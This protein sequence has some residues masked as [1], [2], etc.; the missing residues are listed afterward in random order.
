MNHLPA[1]LCLALAFPALAMSPDEAK[2]HSSN[3][4]ISAAKRHDPAAIRELGRRREQS[5]LRLLREIAI[6]PDVVV[7]DDQV[8]KQKTWASKSAARDKWM[9]DT[10]A[11]QSHLFAK[12]A[13]ARMGDDKYF[14]EFIV[15]ISS[16]NPEWRRQ[17]IVTLGEIQ[18]KRA[19]K[20][21]IPLLDDQSAP[22]GP[23]GEIS[24]PYNFAATAALQTILPD[25]DHEFRNKYGRDG[26]YFVDGWKEWW[27][28]NKDAYEN[29][30]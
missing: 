7:S 10:F 9:Q 25:V 5:S 12:I 8:R 17:C 22:P 30:K 19:V 23:R 21:L 4:L 2:Q 28:G 15:G 27:K 3:D 1:I 6:E 16:T 18:D 24:T 20:F 14:D 26:T 13:L 29:I 11:N